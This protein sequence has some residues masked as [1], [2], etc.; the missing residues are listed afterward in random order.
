MAKIKLK[1]TGK[2]VRAGSTAPKNV[3]GIMNATLLKILAKNNNNKKK[4]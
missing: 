4:T 2:P 3:G 1:F